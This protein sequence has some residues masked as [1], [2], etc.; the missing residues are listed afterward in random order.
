MPFFIFQITF[1]LLAQA[2]LLSLWRKETL[3]CITQILKE[4]QSRFPWMSMS[5]LWSKYSFEGIRVEWTAVW[6]TSWDPHVPRCGSNAAPSVLTTRMEGGAGKET[7]CLWAR[8][9]TAEP[10][11]PRC[12]QEA[13][14]RWCYHSLIHLFTLSFI[15]SFLGEVC[16]QCKKECCRSS[17]YND[18]YWDSSRYSIVSIQTLLKL[19]LTT[20]KGLYCCVIMILFIFIHSSSWKVS[21]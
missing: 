3:F 8:R 14:Q 18:L 10:E 16:I 4:H 7:N 13:V 5:S 21:M 19:E 12:L 20:V 6:N 1:V 17:V 2:L 15:H 9:H 11:L